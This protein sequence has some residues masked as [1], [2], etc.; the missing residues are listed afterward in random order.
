[1]LW[2]IGS[3]IELAYGSPAE[4]GKSCVV[5]IVGDPFTSVFDGESCEPC[6]R[7]QVSGGVGDA[8]EVAED[9]PVLRAWM[10]HT[11]V[12]LI[13]KSVCEGNDIA[14]RVRPAVD[15]RIRGDAYQR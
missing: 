7:H 15:A 8:A 9:G 4:T 2:I 11:A 1:M 12:G 3:G 10:D 6:I 14:W 13:E 5:A